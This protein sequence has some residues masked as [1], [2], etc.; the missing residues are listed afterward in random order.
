[1]FLQGPLKK[2]R[3]KYPC[4]AGK[5]DFVRHSS[6]PESI[7]D[8]SFDVVVMLNSLHCLMDKERSNI[9]MEVKR[10]LKSDGYLFASVLSLEDESYPREKWEEVEAHTFDDGTGKTFHFFSFDELSGEL[11]GLRIL[12]SRVLQNIHPEVE[13]KSVLF[14][15]TA[16]NETA[17]GLKNL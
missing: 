8:D 3:Q 16:K 7:P 2:Q 12:E 13:R 1:M 5:V 6:I 4:K 15:L 14:V 17:S 10:V 11:K 9:L